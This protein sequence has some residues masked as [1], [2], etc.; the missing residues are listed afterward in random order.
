M[1]AGRPV[2]WRPAPT[3][4]SPRWSCSPSGRGHRLVLE[5]DD[6]V[7]GLRD[8]LDLSRR[9]SLRLVFDVHHHACHDPAGI[10]EREALG[11]ALATWPEEPPPK[12]TSPPRGS[13]SA[14]GAART[15]AEW[16][17]CP[18]CPIRGCMPT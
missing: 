15:V 8:A 9:G 10:P 7:F 12:S 14:S 4:S 16:S 18:C 2:A 11:K 17:V 1:S 13:T 6:R 3:A 5:N